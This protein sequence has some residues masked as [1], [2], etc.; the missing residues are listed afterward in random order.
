[1]DIQLYIF[2]KKKLLLL[3]S[4]TTGRWTVP[5]KYIDILAEEETFC[6]IIFGMIQHALEERHFSDAQ[7]L[8]ASSSDLH[9]EMTSF[10]CGGDVITQ[11]KVNVI[12][13][14]GDTT[15]DKSCTI[16]Y[17]QRYRD[18]MWAEMDNPGDLDFAEASRNRMAAALQRLMLT[19]HR[20]HGFLQLSPLEQYLRAAVASITMCAKARYVG[21]G[22]L[23]GEYGMI[24]YYRD[25]PGLSLFIVEMSKER[26]QYMMELG[27]KVVH[28]PRFYPKGV[29]K[30]ETFDFFGWLWKG[31][32]RI[33]TQGITYDSMFHTDGRV[34]LSWVAFTKETV[35]AVAP[36]HD[37]T[38]Q[39]PVQGS[40]QK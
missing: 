26:A 30:T 37:S 14:V 15:F 1:M 29:V 35:T 19:P 7:I 34:K 40:S 8:D 36:R 24:A 12:L 20:Q 31:D 27:H 21:E 2:H 11:R 13:T 5:S 9:M 38:F 10:M 39:I 17:P 6:T 22:G 4:D 18:F 16:N 23:G 32:V 33:H 3:C 25:R 28:Q